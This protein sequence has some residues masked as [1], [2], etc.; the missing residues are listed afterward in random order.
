MKCCITWTFWGS[1]LE[2][3]TARHH[4]TVQTHS[5]THTYI[6]N[7]TYEELQDVDISGLKLT[8]TQRRRRG[9]HISVRKTD[10]KTVRNEEVTEKPFLY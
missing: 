3:L 9:D 5:N 1:H 6:N 8:F 2:Q 4:Q 10:F 7:H